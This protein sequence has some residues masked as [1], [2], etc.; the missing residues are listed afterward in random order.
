MSPIK[1]VLAGTVLTM[2]G[3]PLRD[4]GV[5]W[6]GDRILRAGSRNEILR[7]HPRII[8]DENASIL[9]PGLIN[10]HAHLELTSLKGKIG[11]G[12][13]FT[14]WLVSVISKKKKLEPRAVLAGIRAGEGSLL[15]SGVT[16]VADTASCPAALSA[17]R[18]LRTIIFQEVLGVQRKIKLPATKS[19]HLSPHA[20]YSLS[21]E[22]VRLVSRWWDRRARSLVSMHVG[23]SPE[24]RKY[25]TR[26]RGDFLEFYKR[27]G[28]SPRSFPGRDVIDWL[29]HERL[30]RK[31][32]LAVHL[33]D[34][35][36]E[37]A[38]ILFRRGVCAAVCPGSLEFFGFPPAG[39]RRLIRAGVPVLFGTDS[40]A[41]NSSLNLFREIRLAQKNWGLPFRRLIE[42]VTRLPGEKLWNGRIGKLSPG[43]FADM[44][45]VRRR[46]PR[47]SDAFQ[48][49][50]SGIAERRI[51]LKILSGL[52][53]SRA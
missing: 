26:G 41:S 11:R 45:L 42:S 24:E 4:G 47:D 31:N 23:E 44:I 28:M 53:S 50:F 18:T 5:A 33:N 17:R 39:V 21:D 8:A 37:E 22:N 34:V 12:G 9:M 51:H 52:E 2:D 43:T 30:L 10:A 27:I 29:G 49:L 7:L 40:A 36:A 16:A 38:Q 1:A 13:K 48:D 46:G 25:F 32:L 35:T 20:P 14:D 6:R 19:A 3:E 15:D